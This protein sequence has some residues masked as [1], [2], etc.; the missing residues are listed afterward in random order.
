MSEYVILVSNV[1]S[2]SQFGKNTIEE[3]QAITA[4]YTQLLVTFLIVRGNTHITIF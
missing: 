1:K 3:P 2:V 4:L